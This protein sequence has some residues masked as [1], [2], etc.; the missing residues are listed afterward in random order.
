MRKA[1]ENQLCRQ[2]H[3]GFAARCDLERHAIM[4]ADI[5]DR[6]GRL[7]VGDEDV[8]LAQMADAH[9]RRA[10]EFH[11]VRNQDDVARIGDDGLRGAHFAIVEIE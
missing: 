3:H 10:R 7:L 11:R 6:L 4:P 8:D 9:R 5:D 2:M 1:I